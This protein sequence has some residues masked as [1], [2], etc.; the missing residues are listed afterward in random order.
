[1]WPLVGGRESL[2][3]A[4]YLL[5]FALHAVLISYVVG[6]T[7]YALV[8]ALRGKDDPTAT[9]ARDLLPFMLGLGITAGVAPL[10]FI[11]LLYQRAFYTAN[12][13]LGP[14]W[15]AVVP[16]LI[17]GFYALYLAKSGVHVRWRRLALGAGL[18]CFVFVA[19]SWTEIDQLM[20]AEPV[21][22]AMYVAGDRV[23]GEGSIAPRLLL[24]LGAMATVFAT[25][26]LWWA[27]PDERRRL[28]TIAIAG[29]AV[30]GLA[31]IWLVARG[32]AVGT[33]HGW[34]YILVLALA[35][36]LVGWAWQWSRPANDIRGLITAAATAV[37]L[38]GVVVREAPRLAIVEPVRVAALEASG[39]PVF[40]ITGVFGCAVIAWLVRVSRG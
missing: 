17:V 23:F 7:A 31:A 6:G 22:T 20:Q 15:G 33:A 29:R 30:S 5:T 40:V 28:A 36:E 24:W 32:G 18:A 1:M 3:L 13:L 4:L 11:Q 35:L 38:A 14:R 39:V 21:W 9:R 2:W 19:W 25:L 8:Q 10:L 26:S 34:L 27:Q 37:M 16:A 12:L